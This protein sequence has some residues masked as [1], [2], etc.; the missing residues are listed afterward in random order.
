MSSEAV[1][2]DEAAIDSIHPDAVAAGAKRTP[3]PQEAGNTPT[4]AGTKPEV[5]PPAGDPSH[6]A[7][8]P[9]S[10]RST[11]HGSASQDMEEPAA[12]HPRTAGPEMQ[13]PPSSPHVT[14]SSGPEMEQP[15]LSGVGGMDDTGMRS[16]SADD[17]RTAANPDKLAATAIAASD[18]KN[19]TSNTAGKNSTVKPDVALRE[20][21]NASVAANATDP[22]G[23]PVVCPL[24]SRSINEEDMGP[25]KVSC[26]AGSISGKNVAGSNY[27]LGCGCALNMLAYKTL[28]NSSI[29]NSTAEDDLLDACAHWAFEE[30]VSAGA[31]DAGAVAALKFFH[32]TVSINKLNIASRK[33]LLLC[34]GS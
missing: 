10:G 19:T 11:A 12:G 2:V 15:P 22:E 5:D 16:P 8:E 28:A 31:I 9:P 32:T 18:G 33:F 1:A 14:V 24:T 34:S 27:C 20:F 3:G 26:D 23:V 21:Q 17:V 13:Q 4:K 7:P 6:E 29:L 30:A 25:V